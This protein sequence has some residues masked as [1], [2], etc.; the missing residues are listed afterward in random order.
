MDD[1]YAAEIAAESQ[2]YAFN[3][4]R[5]IMYMGTELKRELRRQR[6]T[7]IPKRGSE[8]KGCSDYKI[9]LERINAYRILSYWGKWYV[10]GDSVPS[11]FRLTLGLGPVPWRLSIAF[12]KSGCDPCTGIIAK[13]PGQSDMKE[14]IEHSQHT[15]ILKLPC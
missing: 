14:L 6:E 5:L 10:L 7:N 8:G 11:A 2:V 4:G 13:G 1:D 3:R 12:A 15:M 9:V